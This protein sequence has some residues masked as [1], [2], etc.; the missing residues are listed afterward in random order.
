[1]QA[2]LKRLITDSSIIKEDADA[3]LDTFSAAGLVK[4]A[5]AASPW[6]GSLSIKPKNTKSSSNKNKNYNHFKGLDETNDL[7]WKQLQKQQRNE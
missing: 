6:T 4:V 5:G 2:E 7:C 1:M 3:I